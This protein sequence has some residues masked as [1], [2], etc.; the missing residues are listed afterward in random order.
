[1]AARSEWSVSEPRT[2]E[3][4]EPVRALTVR[5]AGGTVNVVGTTDGGPPRVEIGEVEGTPLTVSVKDG[6]LSVGY[7]DLP[8]K[9]FLKYLDRRTWRREAVVS[10]AV[11]A[12]T[13]VDVGVV[14]AATVVSGISGR[15]DVHGVTGHLTLVGLTG[16]VRA[17]TVS[18][19]VETQAVTGDL[20]VQSVSGSLTVVEG[21]GA[22]VRAETVSG[23]MALD[24]DPGARGTD[25][26][27]TTVSGEIAIRLPDPADTRVEADTTSGTVANAF[28]DL[29]VSG[30]WGAKRITGRLGAGNGR[31]KVTTVSGG[32]ALLRRPPV[33]DRDEDADPAASP[34][35]ADSAAPADKKVL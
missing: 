16:T 11:P 12:D 22:A 21:A 6:T 35:P 13:R 31:L 20:R 32:L 19:D 7:D 15:A 28:D 18:G 17:E 2:L 24:V 29:R 1:M 26:N 4:D 10:V 23:D 33:E 14:G 5:V 3:I 34:H 27:L 9:G 8:L 25:I 30:Q